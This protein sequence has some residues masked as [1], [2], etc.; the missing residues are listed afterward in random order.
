MVR[1]YEEEAGED[2]RTGE[3]VGIVGAANPRILLDITGSSKHFD[4]RNKWIRQKYKS[5]ISFAVPW[6]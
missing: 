6:A 4:S 2:Y 3:E 1:P 5:P